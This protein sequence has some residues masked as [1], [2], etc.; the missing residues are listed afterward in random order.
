MDGVHVQYSYKH[1]NLVTLTVD[2]TQNARHSSPVPADTQ[3]WHLPSFDER[4]ETKYLYRLHTIDIYFWNQEDALQ[5]VNGVRRVLPQSQIL[6]KNEPAPP[7]THVDD[8]SPVVQKLENVAITDPSYSHGQTRDS[9]GSSTFPGAPTSATPQRQASIT[10]FPGPP[11]SATPQNQEAS[12]F[13]PLA[14]NPAAPAAPEAIK[15]RE[16][17]PPPEDGGVNPLAA[18]ASSDQ[19][20]T[21]DVRYQ[22]QQLGFRAPPPQQTYFSG[23]PTTGP[24]SPYS[25]PQIQQTPSFAPNYQQSPP[26]YQSYNHMPPVT[27]Y[28]NYPGSPGFSSPMSTPGISSPSFPPNTKAGPVPPGGFSNYSYHPQHA[29]AQPLMNDYSVHSQVY[30]PTEAESAVKYKPKKDPSG[31]LEA[32]AGVVEKRFEG[33]LKKIEKRIG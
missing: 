1:S 25:Q 18:A 27:Q 4:N 10:S 2:G 28:A 21:F 14:Y 19:G 30:R 20:Q 5:F 15:H 9:R 33:F 12:N 6:I 24:Q 26:A 23:P 11:I 32:G 22:Q 8:M 16:K 17:T 7:P 31:K 3:E 29:H 13:A